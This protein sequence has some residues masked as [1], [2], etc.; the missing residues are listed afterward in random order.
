MIEGLQHAGTESVTFLFRDVII[1]AVVGTDVNV[2]NG[3][4]IVQVTLEG[5]LGEF[6]FLPADLVLI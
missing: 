5:T 2:E 1:V 4:D 6:E 3:T